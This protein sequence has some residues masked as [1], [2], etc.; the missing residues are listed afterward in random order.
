MSLSRSRWRSHGGFGSE[1]IDPGRLSTLTREDGSTQ[2]AYAG[3]P[4]YR[5]A[6]DQQPGDVNGH[7]FNDVW[8]AL[9]PDGSAIEHEGT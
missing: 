3:N 4:L 9:G 5:Y 6:P 7:G 1:P 2:V 8:F